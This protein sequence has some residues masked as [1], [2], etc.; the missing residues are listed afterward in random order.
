MTQVFRGSGL[1]D[2]ADPPWHDHIC[3][4]DLA[5][6]AIGR[7]RDGGFG[8]PVLLLEEFFDLP[9]IDVESA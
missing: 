7:G 8:N 4:G 3:D 9:R 2:R 1:R 6:H 5:T